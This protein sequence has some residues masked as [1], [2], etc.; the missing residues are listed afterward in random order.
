[1]PLHAPYNR[2]IKSNIADVA[3]SSG[4]PY[5]GSVTAALFLER[6]VE[7]GCPWLHFDIMAWNPRPRPG[8][9]Q[10]GEAMALRA[11]FDYLESRFRA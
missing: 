6:F 7:I 9:P 8:H 3:N 1:M 10:G 11:V 4:T 5:A 2:L